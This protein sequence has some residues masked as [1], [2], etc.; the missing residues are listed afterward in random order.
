MYG[1][2]NFRSEPLTDDQLRAR[3]P[4]IFATEPHESRSKRYVYIPTIQIVNALRKEGFLPFAAKQAVSRVPGKA[5][6]T[7]HL[8]RFRQFD[9]GD[10]NKGDIIPELALLN[11]HDGS[12]RYKLMTALFRVLCLNGLI[13]KTGDGDEVSVPHSGKVEQE[14]IEGSFRVIDQSVKLLEAPKNWGAIELKQTE[15]LALANA[16]HTLRFADAEGEVTT[17]VQPG[18]L[19]TAHREA[20]RRNDLWTT[21]NRIQ[22]NVIKGGL[23]A[24]QEPAQGQPH[25][26]MVTTREVKGIDADVKLNRALWALTQEMY[27]LKLAA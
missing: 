15:Q 16:A 9:L 21:F 14:V 25:G 2:G 23:S 12:S 6:F 8:L 7:K 17:P 19:L 11:S 24:R 26:R 27:R 18:Q 13:A 22:E 3:A 5:D 1:R 4:S 10:I 20:D